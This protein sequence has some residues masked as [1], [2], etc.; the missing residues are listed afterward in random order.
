MIPQG[1][2]DR[3]GRVFFT[4]GDVE[5]I[6]KYATTVEPIVLPEQRP[7]DQQLRLFG[8]GNGPGSG[9]AQ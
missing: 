4:P 6:D 7:D 2:R 9:G 1:H 8:A 3:R 5:V